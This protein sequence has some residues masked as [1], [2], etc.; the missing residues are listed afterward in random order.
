MQ[1]MH[2]GADLRSKAPSPSVI[3][4]TLP[5]CA[6][7]QFAY[8]DHFWFGGSLSVTPASQVIHH[9]SDRQAAST[10]SYWCRKSANWISLMQSDSFWLHTNWNYQAN[11]IKKIPPKCLL[12]R[13]MIYIWW[14]SKLIIDIGRRRRQRHGFTC[15]GVAPSCVGGALVLNHQ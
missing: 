6:H 13:T 2:T 10:T 7:A 8:K 12:M 14:F 5:I 1:T 4:S 3:G 15:K 9:F 11:V